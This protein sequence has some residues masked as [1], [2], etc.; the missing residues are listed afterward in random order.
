MVWA[1][2]ALPGI[3]LWFIAALLLAI[4]R[5]RKIVLADPLRFQL[6]RQNPKGEAGQRVPGRGSRMR[7]S[8]T[9]DWPLY[10]KLP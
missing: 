7:S 8:S 5:N 2:L 10:W 4:F 6:K 1:L 9:K 3:Q